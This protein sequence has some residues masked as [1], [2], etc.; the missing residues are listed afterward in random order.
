MPRIFTLTARRRG[1]LALSGDRFFRVLVFSVAVLILLF[2]IFN[3]QIYPGASALAVAAAN[4]RAE[5]LIATAFATQMQSDTALYDGLVTLYE[6][7]DGSISGLRC[8]TPRLNRARNQL[9]LSVL[10]GLRAEDALTVDLPLG[11]LL[12]GE[13]FSGRGPTLPVRVLLAGTASAHMASEFTS[14]GINQTLHRVLFTVTVKMTVMLPSHPVDTTVTHSFCVAETLIVGEVPD[15]FID[16]N[17]L[18]DD[19]NEGEIDDIFD[20]GIGLS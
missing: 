9:F 5:A 13:A 7:A 15:T 3:L 12:G 18:T 19:I 10:E 11:N 6:R 14:S 8:D 20:Y 17:R 1:R 16:I 2:L 4:S